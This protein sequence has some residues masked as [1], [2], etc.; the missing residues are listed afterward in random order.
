M[1]PITSPIAGLAC[2]IFRQEIEALR[3]AGQIHWPF[4][5][6]GSMLHMTPDRLEQQ[7]QS[8]LDAWP[9]NQPILL[10]YGDCCPHMLDLESRPQV[11]RTHGINCCE[12]LLGR[13]AYRKLRAEG[14]FFLIPEW[15]W[16][17]REIFE[18]TLG[19][20]GE[21]ARDFMRDMHTAL[22]YLDTGLTP[23]PH[24][25]LADISAYSGLPLSILPITLD[26]LLASL[27]EAADRIA[28]HG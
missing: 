25:T 8:T 24:P 14:A 22:I 28:P 6:L 26:P 11:A 12:V 5:Y 21:T 2:S 10:A 18:Q 19:L 17:W 15:A 4:R 3:A 7:L 23:I 9:A 1:P 13:A 20:Q 16:R 27:N